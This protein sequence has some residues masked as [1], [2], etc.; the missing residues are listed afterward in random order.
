MNSEQLILVDETDQEIGTAEK[1]FAHKNALLHRAFSVFIFRQNNG[2]VE[3]LLQR[4]NRQKY[5]CGGL[6]TNTC[7]GHPR[8][9]EK[10]MDAAM[11]RLQ[12]EMGFQ[13]PLEY[14]STFQYTA[15]FTNGLTEREIDHVFMAMVESPSIKPASEEVD[16]Y[17]WDL[18][19][20]VQ[21]D[22][23]EHPEQYT[24]WFEQALCS[25]PLTR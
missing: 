14:V 23:K 3:L 8:P 16:D 4:R 24:P 9:G 21:T 11:R 18:V 19:S 12:E 6:W 1:I 2:N 13:V 10:T 22:L 7:C 5:H 25:I 15:E 17:R 20:A